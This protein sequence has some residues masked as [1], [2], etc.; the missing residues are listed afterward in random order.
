MWWQAFRNKLVDFISGGHPDLPEFQNGFKLVTSSLPFRWDNES[1]A[2]WIAWETIAN[3][4][5]KW[6]PE[7]FPQPAHRVEDAYFAF[8]T[9]VQIPAINSD[10]QKKSDAIRDTIVD[11]IQEIEKARVSH[12]PNDQKISLLENQLQNLL[13]N[14]AASSNQ[15]GGGYQELGQALLNYYNPAYQIELEDDNNQR[16]SYRTWHF[17]PDPNDFIESCKQGKSQRLELDLDASLLNAPNEDFDFVSNS[18]IAVKNEPAS[19]ETTSQN[20]QIHK[21]IFKTDGFAKIDI[22]PG[23][24]FNHDILMSYKEYMDR[25]VQYFG[26]RKEPFP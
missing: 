13:A 5:P 3:Q 6:T 9:N 2:K 4:I 17:I 7:Y 24:W 22:V 19:S 10:A 23:Q 26:E 18:F 12:I 1:D 16:F 14:W 21:I 25:V 20:I 8:L 15:A 11:A